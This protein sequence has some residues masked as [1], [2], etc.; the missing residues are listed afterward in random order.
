MAKI[1]RAGRRFLDLF[2]M[3]ETLPAEIK[4][5]Y[6]IETVKDFRDNDFYLNF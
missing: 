4:D 6:Q 3:G 5:Y 2:T 1:R